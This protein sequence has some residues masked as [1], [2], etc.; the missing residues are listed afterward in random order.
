[1]VLMR[2]K[3]RVL[4][5]LHASPGQHTTEI[6]EELRLCSVGV[7]YEFVGCVLDARMAFP[8]WLTLR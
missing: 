5:T 8:Q 4:V 3:R 7:A 6:N 1:M 2:G